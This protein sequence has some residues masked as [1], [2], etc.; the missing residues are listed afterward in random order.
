MLG[1][2]GLYFYVEGVYFYRDFKVFFILRDYMILI[3]FLNCLYLLCIGF[4]FWLIFIWKI[5][6][7]I[8]IRYGL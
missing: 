6:L 7:D 2:W 4:L 1:C 5:M 3:L 8:I